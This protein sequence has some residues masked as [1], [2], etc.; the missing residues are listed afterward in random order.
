[1]RRR[2]EHDLVGSGR[3]D[4]EWL[5]WF[6]GLLADQGYDVASPRGGGQ[7]GLAKETGIAQS[8][9]SRILDGQVPG[10]DNQLILS[11]VLGVD[12]E[13]FL[14][15]TGKATEADFPHRGAGSGQIGVSSGKVLTP[16][17]IA[18]LAGVPEDDQPWFTTML[19]RFRR[20]GDNGDS[21]AGGAA[22]EG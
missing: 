9:I 12:L 7:A 11:R 18:A 13:E 14:I 15:R 22:A 21:A 10:Y 6:R 20:G 1:M 4:P 16:E 2:D 19:R 17:E 8:T 5:T 3:R